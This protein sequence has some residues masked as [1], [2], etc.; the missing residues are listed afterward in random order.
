MSV[1]K[2][3]MLI[4]HYLS[5]DSAMHHLL[6]LPPM[7]PIITILIRATLLL[8]EALLLINISTLSTPLGRLIFASIFLFITFLFG[9]VNGPGIMLGRT[10]DSDQFQRLIF[11]GIVE[12]MFRPGRHDHHVTGFDILFC[13]P[14]ANSSSQILNTREIKVDG[15]KK[16]VCI[17]ILNIPVPFPPQ[18]LFPRPK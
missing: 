6:N 15:V 3:Q 12:L 17:I 9:L 4:T 8:D 7:T 13:H 18:Q 10:I 16:A 1:R 14:S 5:I 2:H 11:T